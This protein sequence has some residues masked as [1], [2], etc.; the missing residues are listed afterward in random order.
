MINPEMVNYEWGQHGPWELPEWMEPY[1][2]L[3]GDTGGNPVEWLMSLSGKDT[4]SNIILGALCVS[5]SA[6]V[7]LLMRLH[8][9]GFLC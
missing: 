3:I 1:R 8:K 7:T 2:D 5:V 6:Q 4:K 9:G